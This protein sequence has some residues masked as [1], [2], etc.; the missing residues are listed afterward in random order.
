M[1]I[2]KHIPI[3]S[4]P[5]KMLSYAANDNYIRKE[6]HI[7]LNYASIFLFIQIFKI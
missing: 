6:Q 1:P 7:D 4:A 3:Y 5:K 2:I